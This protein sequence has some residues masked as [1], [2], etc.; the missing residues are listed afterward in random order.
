[1]ST[2]S[3]TM[4]TP[5]LGDEAHERTEASFLCCEISSLGLRL[6]DFAL[7]IADVGLLD[8]EW[9]ADADRTPRRPTVRTSSRRCC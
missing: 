1:M 7:S 4:H 3:E 6:E 8:T 9:S 2:N 5:V